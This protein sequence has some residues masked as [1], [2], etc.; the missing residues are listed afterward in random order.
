MS[1][2]VPDSPDTL[3]HSNS[4][5]SSFLNFDIEIR[6]TLSDVADHENPLNL[7][8]DQG[9]SRSRN[10]VLIPSHLWNL[11]YITF[12]SEILEAASQLDGERVSKLF[13]QSIFSP[14]PTPSASMN[15]PH[16][17]FH[18][19]IQPITPYDGT[20]GKLRPFCSQLLNQ[21]NAESLVSETEKVRFTY[22]FLGPGALAKMRSF[23]RCLENPSISPKITALEGLL[24]ALKQRCEDIGLRD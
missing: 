11:P 13:E 2:R 21:I 5:N 16:S 12:L 4:T 20:P 1:Y 6:Q 19:P 3:A 24:L 8:Q 7:P 22:Q 23:F 18:L 10:I 14:T 15:P 9:H 17:R